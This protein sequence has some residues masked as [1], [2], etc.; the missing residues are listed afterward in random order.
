MVDDVRV[1]S[2]AL[3]RTPPPDAELL[4][5]WVEPAERLGAQHDVRIEGERLLA[6][7]RREHRRYHDVVHLVTV[8]RHVDDLAPVA[9][10]ADLVRV[11]AW[12]HDAVY[13]VRRDDNEAAS[14]VLA[15]TVLDRLDVD[16]DVV[17]EVSRLVRLTADHVA[18]P[19]DRD[20]AVLCDADLAVLAGPADDYADYAA[21]VRAEHAHVDDATFASARAD[22]LRRLLDRPTLFR[23]PHGREHWEAPARHNLVQELRFLSP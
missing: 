18:D 17:A 21:G 1:L 5:L 6:A 9:G 12:F 10:D 14:A 20:G 4:A 23:T 15:E 8:L 13:D 7:Y 22:V 11:A 16:P 19:A 3:S 2:N